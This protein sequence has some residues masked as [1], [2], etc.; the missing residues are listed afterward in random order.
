MAIERQQE[1]EAATINTLE[2]C[3]HAESHHAL[4]CARE[5]FKQSLVD[6]GCFL[7]PFRTLVL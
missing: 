3:A 4:T 1:R 5:V 2:E 7:Y 6:G